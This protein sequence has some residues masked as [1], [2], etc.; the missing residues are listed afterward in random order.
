MDKKELTEVEQWENELKDTKIRFAICLI[1]SILILLSVGSFESRQFM[2]QKLNYFKS[3]W[4]LNDLLL[5]VSVLCITIVEIFYIKE[6]KYNLNEAILAAAEAL[7]VEEEVAS[8]DN[9]LVRLLKPKPKGGGGGGA[10]NEAT[11]IIGDDG[12]PLTLP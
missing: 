10:N 7:L 8:D 3:V 11:V 1:N 12:Q 4:N 9:I 6:A 5:I 2:T